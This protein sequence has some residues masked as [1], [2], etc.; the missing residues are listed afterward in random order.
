MFNF[1][2]R[3]K[4]QET[5]DIDSL[6][7]ESMKVIQNSNL[8]ITKTLE[9]L[10]QINTPNAIL[11]NTTKET[12]TEETKEVIKEIKTFDVNVLNACKSKGGSQ[13]YFLKA[14]GT[15][16]ADDFQFKGTH[17]AINKKNKTITLFLTGSK[18][19]KHGQIKKMMGLI[20]AMINRG[21]IEGQKMTVGGVKD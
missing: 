13:D 12:P 4:K 20:V 2:K 18:D 6:I 15:E 10:A 5:R 8:A 14:E 7:L 1:L 11:S 3:N 9:T 16:W 17:T 19:M 21:R